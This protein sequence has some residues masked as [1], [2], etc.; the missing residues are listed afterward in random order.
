M[1][2]DAGAQ[3]I[4]D[5]LN[6]PSTQ[7]YTNF[8]ALAKAQRKQVKRPYGV[9]AQYGVDALAEIRTFYRDLRAQ[10]DAIETVDLDS[11]ASALEA[12]DTIDLSIGAYERSL[13]F[14]ISRPAIP[15]AK[16]AA[17]RGK[18]AKKSINQAIN[19]LSQ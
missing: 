4:L 8:V 13:E 1:A 6:Q 3:Q 9:L 11:K 5:L 16:K 19:G 2:A 17:Q 18:L 10:I 12:L 7:L 14:G 15:K